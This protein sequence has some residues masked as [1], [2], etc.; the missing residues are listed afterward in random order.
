L[1]KDDFQIEDILTKCR[2]NDRGAQ[3]ELYKLFYS[4]GMNICLRYSGDRQDA[5]A[6]MNDGFMKVF[7]HVK[8]FDL[9][10]PF[11]PWFRKILINC[12]IDHFNRSKRH[13]ELLQLEEG[14]H[15]MEE[16]VIEERISYADMIIIIQ[17]LPH[18]YRTVFN[19][20]AIEGY[21][22]D[23]VAA[24]LDISVGTSKSNYHRAKQKLQEFLKEYFIER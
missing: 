24:M 15:V 23:E 13:V 21:K 20:I 1:S 8:R 4:Y 7:Q 11:K 22:H 19:L 10:R 6:I 18:A 14:L 2:K 3:K 16:H 5:V 12:A 17:R 9:N